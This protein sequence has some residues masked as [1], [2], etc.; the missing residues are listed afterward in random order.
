MAGGAAG[1]A[2]SVNDANAAKLQLEESRRHNKKMED[3]AIGKGLYLKPYKTGLGLRLKP[4]QRG[5]ELSKKKR[6]SK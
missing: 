6:T 2:K 3:I 1:I 5:S 4:Y